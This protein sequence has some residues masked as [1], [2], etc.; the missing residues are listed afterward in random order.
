MRDRAF[1]ME[2]PARVS[3]V[4]P[5]EPTGSGDGFDRA[6]GGA[7]YKSAPKWGSDLLSVQFG[8]RMVTLSRRDA[9]GAGQG[10]HGHTSGA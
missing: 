2:R 4:G 7:G 10:E 3:G 6:P 1:V 8:Y 5:P 9:H